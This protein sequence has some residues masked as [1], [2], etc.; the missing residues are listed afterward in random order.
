VDTAEEG[1]NKVAPGYPQDFFLFVYC[2]PK[3]IYFLESLLGGGLSTS[4]PHPLHTQNV[5]E[6]AL[7]LCIPYL[8]GK[9]C[10]FMYE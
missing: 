4:Y 5:V 6:V 1:S 3:S 2:K 10:I 8:W 7:E 9:A